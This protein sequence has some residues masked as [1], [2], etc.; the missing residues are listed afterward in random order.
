MRPPYL[1]ATLTQLRFDAPSN[2]DQCARI[3]MQARAMLRALTAVSVVG[4][5]FASY[6]VGGREKPETIRRKRID[7]PANARDVKEL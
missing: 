6:M 5:F 4:L 3:E 1:A 2:E 7:E